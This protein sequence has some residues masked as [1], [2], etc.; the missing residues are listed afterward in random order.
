[1]KVYGGG[2]SCRWSSN[3]VVMPWSFDRGRNPS[4]PSNNNDEDKKPAA[5]KKSTPPQSTTRRSARSKN[6]DKIV[7]PGFGTE[8]DL[9]QLSTELGLPVQAVTSIMHARGRGIKRR[10]GGDEATA[11]TTGG[12][13]EPAT[14]IAN[15]WADFMQE[16][17][18]MQSGSQNEASKKKK[19]TGASSSSDTA[20][21][22]ELPLVRKTGE[23]GVLLQ[24]GTLDS[25][26]IGRSKRTMDQPYDLLV[27]TVL[28]SPKIAIHKIIASCSAAHMLAVSTSNVVYGWGRNEALQ[29]SHQ[30][31]ASTVAI[32]TVLEFNNIEDDIVDGAVGKSH[33]VLLT[34]VGKLYAVGSNKVGQCGVNSS[35]D[36]VPNWRKCVGVEDEV[37]QVSCGEQFTVA[38]THKGQLYTTGSSE[39]G[40]LGNGETGEYFISANKLAFAN[41]TTFTL[42]TEFVY[43][44]EYNPHSSA[45]SSDKTVATIPHD[46]RIGSI[47]CGKNHSIAIEASSSSGHPARVFTWGCGNYGC[48]GH[49]MQVD[50]YKP[51]HV[52]SLAGPML[53]SNP[54]VKA[55]AGSHCSLIQTKN[56]HVY[57][58]GKHRSVGEA[59]MRPALLDALANNGHV[60][61]SIGAGSQTVVCST[62][63]A[64]TVAWGQGPYGELGYGPDEKS[65]A[66]PQFV[67]SLDNCRIVDLACGQGTTLFLAKNQ[68]KDGKE[69]IKKLPVMK[70]SDAAGLQ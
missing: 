40:Q 62:Q 61:T 31:D 43:D 50:S 68:D 44:T 41:C 64:A 33:T 51:R 59:T 32:P 13:E 70:E 57:Y 36:S 54:P 5:K 16:E 67:D 45:S 18:M 65:S 30:F 4:T 27:P 60:V 22:Y 46:I 37:V 48:L 38:L 3:A 52:Q 39:F 8:R 12:V 6:R 66:K 35:T 69:A 55:A 2:E 29:L 23:S 58:F 28:L 25:S 10:G 26:V 17:G 24:T 1:M 49:G 19:T 9:Q 47:A 15:A 11:T 20:R 56:G 53:E 7:A 21:D 14:P 34:D 63:G 42:R